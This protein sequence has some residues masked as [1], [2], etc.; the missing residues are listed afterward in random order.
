MLKQ[1]QYKIKGMNRDLSFFAFN[2]EFAFENKNIRITPIE[3]NTL[4]SIVNEKGTLPLKLTGESISD[5][6]I[7]GNVLGYSVINDDS[8][9]N[10][11]VNNL[12]SL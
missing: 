12:F 1:A 7:Q 2:P 4:F 6:I 9:I 11:C 3:G 10:C 8:L 5:N